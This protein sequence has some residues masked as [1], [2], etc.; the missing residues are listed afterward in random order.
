[1]VDSPSGIVVVGGNRNRVGAT[2]RSR[3]SCSWLISESAWIGAL[4]DIMSIFSIVEAPP[5]SRQQVLGS[6]GPPNILIPSSR[7][8]EIVGAQNH[9]ALQ[10]KNPC[11]VD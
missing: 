7:V 8:M 10:G 2:G 3:C 6:L 1:M 5:I 11:P 4:V 9:F